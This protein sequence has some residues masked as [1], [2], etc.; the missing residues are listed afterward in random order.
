LGGFAALAASSTP[1]STAL[2]ELD[3]VTVVGKTPQPL[4]EAAATVS[5][6]SAGDLE[7]RLAFDPGDV[8]RNEPGLSVRRDP[9]RFGYTTITVR[10]LG[11]NRVVTETD[12]VPSPSTFSIGS[13]SDAGR[14]FTDPEL[15][16][17]IEILKGPAST[18]Y[19][20]DAIGGV[21]ATTTVDPADLLKDDVDDALRLRTGYASDSHAAMAS[22]TA[23]ARFDTF[24]GML[25][26]ARREGS[27]L[28]NAYH[29]VDANPQDYGAYSVLARAVVHGPGQPFR[30]TLGRE[31]QSARTDVNS[32]ELSGGRFANTIFLRG[33]DTV[34]TWRFI[35]DQTLELASAVDQL[36][37]RLFLLDTRFLQLTDEERRSAPP[38]T[39]PLA[40]QRDF[41]YQ[42]TAAGGEATLTRRIDSGFGTHRLVGGAELTRTRIEERRNG[43][44]TNLV[45]LAT[46]G[47][48][49]G[50]VL[51]VR[52]FPISDL[53]KA[54]VYVQDEWR[55]AEGR[56][57]LFPALRAD[58]YR[59][60]PTVDAM[61][62]ADNPSQNPVSVRQFSLAPKLGASIRASDDL[63]L[64]LQYS[65]G[66]RSQPFE[67]V[68]IGLDLPQFNVR[69]IP[70]PDLK[71]EESDSI[72]IGA[73]LSDGS[74]TGSASLF[75]SRYRDFIESKVN[76]GPD[77]Q[78]G[79]NLFQSRNIGKARI[80]GAEVSFEA[81]FGD[82]LAALRG[83]S[84]RLSAAWNRGEDAVS[85]L[86]INTIDPERGTIGIR[87]EAPSQL[88]LAQLTLTAVGA[89]DRVD[90]SRG[91][92]FR[93][94]GYATIDLTG[95]WRISDRVRLHAGVFNLADRSYYE[96]ADVRGR[97]PDD[98][99][100]D[101]YHQPGRNASLT[102]TAAF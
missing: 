100:L 68:N 21:I 80:Y 71:P 63:L 2:P 62:A 94:S 67:D 4:A 92:L 17:R 78:T 39:P 6:I 10:G 83:F 73:R 61:Y 12:G 20:S 53:L 1:A 82:W 47:T 15:I 14:Q 66:F 36:E 69:A 41:R 49:L 95:Q 76:I 93:P 74:V 81:D 45:T 11:G 27:E 35:V 5:V 43:L 102:L 58:W 88:W 55:P 60:R 22:M 7:D 79:A 72:E 54:G 97:R 52:D 90:D 34:D 50:E 16:K 26:L 65:H 9:N 70:N 64:F 19:G 23:A 59:L 37:W 89:A 29:V 56:W 75:Y 25:S 86:P 8:F 51:P 42:E 18:L 99:L 31:R 40:I 32:L 91:P 33:D 77:P 46:T 98:P 101:L 24:D 48:I 96:W 44:Q 87:F 85:G 30:L 13:F 28:Q 3:L 84:G 57:T 38:A